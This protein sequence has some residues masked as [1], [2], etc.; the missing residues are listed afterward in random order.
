M[1]TL[2]AVVLAQALL[3]LMEILERGLGASRDSAIQR[4]S[5]S[6]SV[7]ILSERILDDA[8]WR[9]RDGA[10]KALERAGTMSLPLLFNTAKGHSKFDAR[11]IAIRAIGRVGGVGWCDSLETLIDTPG[12][13]SAIEAMGRTGGCRPVVFERFLQDPDSDI[14]RRALLA[15]S[16]SSG[17]DLVARAL[18]GIEDPN[19]GVRIVASRILSGLG[20]EAS[21]DLVERIPQMRDVSRTLAIRTLGFTGGDDAFAYAQKAL[22]SDEWAD[23]AAAADALQAL[24]REQALASLRFALDKETVTYVRLRVQSAISSLEEASRNERDRD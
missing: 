23:R 1:M 19:Y 20:G 17:P 12:R 15:Y 6:D 10:V 4:L 21:R 9:G 2:A 22:T 5:G 14:R 18:E 13:G 16:R 8:N 7:L 3:G 24:R 11:A